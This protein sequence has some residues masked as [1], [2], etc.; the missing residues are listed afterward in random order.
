MNIINM[1][2]PS[3]EVP[4]DLRELPVDLRRMLKI[5]WKEFVHTFEDYELSVRAQQL[6][7]IDLLRR[8]NAA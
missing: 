5:Q 6:R 8:R 4:V 2:K 3:N 1:K 7:V